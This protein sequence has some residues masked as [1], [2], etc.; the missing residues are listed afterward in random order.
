MAY[1]TIEQFRQIYDEWQQSGL[2]VQRYCENAGIRES[3]FYY[4]KAMLKAE[5]PPAACV[6]WGRGI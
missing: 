5:S 3:R 1:M 4:W 6:S 2:C